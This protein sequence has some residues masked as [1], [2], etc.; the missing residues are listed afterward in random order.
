[1]WSALTSGQSFTVD[2]T[3]RRK[4]GSLYQEESV[5]SPVVDDTGATTSFVAVK[6]D[7]TR[8]RVPG[9]GTPSRGGMRT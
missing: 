8:E 3:N 9:K 4:D 2:I 5:V 1:M 7:V 6:R